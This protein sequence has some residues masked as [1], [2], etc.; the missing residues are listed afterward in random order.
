MLDTLAILL[1]ALDLGV[2]LG[3]A[4]LIW[5]LRGPRRLASALLLALG[6]GAAGLLALM[7]SKYWFG[8]QEF[9]HA[10]IA[11]DLTDLVWQS[12]RT[13]L[14]LAVGLGVAWLVYRRLRCGAGARWAG[15]L[16]VPLVLLPAVAAAGTGALVALSRPPD[17]PPAEVAQRQLRVVDG[18]SISLYSQ[19]SIH[20]PT[21]LT[22]GPD[23]RLYLADLPGRIWALDAASDRVTPR[24]F[25]GGFTE[26]V[27]IVWRGDTLYV[28]ARG[29]ISAV[30]DRDGDGRADETRDILSGLPARLYPLHQNNG[31]A[32]GP[33]GRLY[34]GLGSTHDRQPEERP[35]T[36]AI[37]SVRPDGSDLQVVAHGVRNAY[38]LAFNR[39]GDLFAGD[40]QPASLAV[41]PGDELNQIIPGASYG[42]PYYFEQPPPGSGT[43]GPVYVFPPHSSPVGITFYSGR[44]FPA[45]YDDNGFIGLWMRGEVYRLQLDKLTNGRYAA[46]ASIFAS[47]FVN[48]IDLA[49][50]AD[51]ALYVADYGTSA[52]YRIAPDSLAAR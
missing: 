47:G 19:G 33:D 6:L 28:A 34:F 12:A 25:A 32:F 3:G 21:S 18:F 40:N 8:D 10:F 41:A 7:S 37:L 51:G 14:A 52:I 27:G 9:F 35:I 43:I 2:A 22:L 29:V 38:D 24:L 49:V 31:M 15:T 20:H 39:A 11:I 23:G 26:P 13:L 44:A 48:P 16:L 1:F 30:R 4:A 5:R 45:E 50:G 42:Y 17:P 46:R 36:A